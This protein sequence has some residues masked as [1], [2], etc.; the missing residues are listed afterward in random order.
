MEEV[1]TKDSLFTGRAISGLSLQKNHQLML[2][3]FVDD[4]S[5]LC[6]AGIPIGCDE[7]WNNS[8][9]AFY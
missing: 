4:L 7:K 2:H 5:C 9:K 3:I 1:R 8:D 6:S